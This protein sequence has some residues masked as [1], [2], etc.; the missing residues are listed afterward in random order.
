MQVSEQRDLGVVRLCL[1]EERAEEAEKL[2]G[3]GLELLKLLKL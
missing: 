2:I 3:R 1:G